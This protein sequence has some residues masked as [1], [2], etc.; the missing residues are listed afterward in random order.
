MI[1]IFSLAGF[2]VILVILYLAIFLFTH[3]PKSYPPAEDLETCAWSTLRNHVPLL[4]VPPI[5]RSE[6]LSR[7]ATLASALREEGIDAYITEPSPSSMYYF[8]ISNTYELSERPFLAILSSNGSFSYLAPKFELG[9][10]SGLDM[11]YEEKSVIEWKEEE[12]PYNVLRRA[13][14]SESPKVV[15][16][17]QARFFIA[18]GLQS[19]NFTVSPVSH[20]IASI[21]AVK[22]SAELQI[23]RGI[24]EFTVEVVRSLQ[25]CIQIGVSQETLFSTASALFSRAGVGSGFWAIVLFGEQAANPHGGSKGKTLGAGEFALID[26]GSTLHGYGSDVTRTILPR[27]GN[28]SR[29]L[30]DVWDLVHASQ[31]TAIGLMRPGAPCSTVDEASRYVPYLISS[32]LASHPNCPH[33][34]P[35]VRSFNVIP[36]RRPCNRNV[37]AKGSYGPYFTHRLGHGLGLEMHEHPYLNGANDE[38]LKFAEVVTNEPVFPPPPLSFPFPFALPMIWNNNKTM[39]METNARKG[40]LRDG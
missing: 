11:V 4:D 34:S 15:V 18:S 1:L 17:E 16:D 19:A 24:N 31:S 33:P 23:L 8:N 9:R 32:Y 2:L 3:S 37:I 27:G 29:E 21:R 28:V 14:G 25:P 30:M 39:T 13:F 20:S 12:S 7:Q 5:S 36:N 35:P 10:I 40:N 26:I 38:L 6:F 22:S